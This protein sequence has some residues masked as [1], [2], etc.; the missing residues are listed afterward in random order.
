MFYVV[1]FYV[2]LLKI[3][4]FISYILDRAE[5]FTQFCEKEMFLNGLLCVKRL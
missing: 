1:M 5:R 3:C 2:L 4:Y